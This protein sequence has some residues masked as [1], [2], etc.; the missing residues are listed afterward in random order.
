LHKKVGNKV[1]TNEHLFTIYAE[2]KDKLRFTIRE[3]L[4]NLMKI[5]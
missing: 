5:D 1:N 4:N 3:N 2:S